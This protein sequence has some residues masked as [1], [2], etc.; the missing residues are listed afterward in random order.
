M[1]NK[2]RWQLCKTF[3]NLF[4]S[5]LLKWHLGTTVVHSKSSL[6]G[7]LNLQELQ[8][9]SN[10]N[11][12]AAD[13]T[14]IT[15]GGC[16]TLRGGGCHQAPGLCCWGLGPYVVL[17]MMDFPVH[18]GEMRLFLI[19]CVTQAR[20][21]SLAVQQLEGNTSIFRDRL[22]SWGKKLK[23]CGGQTRLQLP[24]HDERPFGRP[25]GSMF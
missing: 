24:L 15:H 11:K 10:H 7:E 12:W 6:S 23:N 16:S 18:L 13:E 14:G 1:L 22:T 4:F 20:W 3:W 25:L 9:Q 2:G 8:L 5:K 19:M 21:R 17:W